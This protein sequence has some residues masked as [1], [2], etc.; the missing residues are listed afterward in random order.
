MSTFFGLIELI[1]MVTMIVYLVK[2]FR[3]RKKDYDKSRTFLKYFFYSLGIVFVCSIITSFTDDSSSTH[4]ETKQEQAQNA[5]KAK[6]ASEEKADKEY[7][8]EQKNKT[9]QED[10]KRLRSELSKVSSS[11]NG[12]IE[13]ASID[14]NGNLSAIMSDQV[15]EGNSAQIKEVA[16]TAADSLSKLVDRNYPLPSPYDQADVGVTILD[17]AGN[18]LYQAPTSPF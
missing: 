13:S 1:A 10:L 18:V 9:K 14:S 7:A 17:N 3:N 15:L 16:K 5:K 2:F 12:V 4:H 6:Q 11:T 8:K